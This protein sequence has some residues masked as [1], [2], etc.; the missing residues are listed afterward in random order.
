MIVGTIDAAS[1]IGL[2]ARAG[3]MTV[4]PVTTAGSLLMLGSN[5]VTLA[6]ASTGTGANQAVYIADISMESL[7]GPDFD[8]TPLFAL[9]PVRMAGPITINGAITTGSF[10]AASTGAFSAQS[11]SVTGQLYADTGQT[12][13]LTAPIVVPGDVTLTGDGGIDTVDLQAGGDV[14]LYT[15]NGTISVVDIQAG[16][17]AQ[18]EAA[19]LISGGDITAFGVDVLSYG[20]NISL[21][22]LASSVTAADLPETP[23]GVAVHANGSVST[24]AISSQN[25]VGLVA[26]TGGI[27]TNMISAANGDVGVLAATGAS[28]GG[29]TTAPTGTIYIA[30]VSQLSLLVPPGFDPT[31]LFASAPVRINGSV[32]IGGPVST[33]QFTAAGQSFT[34]QGALS[35]QTS[36]N[37]DVAGLATF[38]GIA[39]APTIRVA[40]GDIA[41][42]ANGG[43]GSSGTTSLTLSTT[44][45]NAVIGG[46]GT[47]SGYM[48]DGA[49]AQRVRAANIL[50]GSSGNVELRGL[51]LNGA[52][53][54][55]G[56]NITNPT[57]AFTVQSGGS[58][59]VTGAVRFDNMSS[60]NALR[61]SAADRVE[62][63][64]DTGSIGIYG[65]GTT[66]GGGLEI[67]GD[68]IHVASAS[69]LSQLASNPRF[70]GRDQAL[71]RA[72]GQSRPEGFIQAGRIQLAGRDTILI[73]NSNSTGAFGGFTAGQGGLQVISLAASTAPT[74][75][76]IYGRLADGS[77]GFVI[78]Q[79]VRDAISISSSSQGGFSASSSVN[80]CLLSASVCDAAA[81]VPEQ[82]D[83]V[84]SIATDVQAIANQSADPQPLLEEEEQE[85]AQKATSRSPIARPVALID[86]RPMDADP[87][88]EEP[89]T[90]GGNPSLIGNVEPS[91]T[92]SGGGQ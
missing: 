38:N 79:D 90:S 52:Q 9:L 56:A 81:P 29:I 76:V 23:F 66:L 54:G 8:P 36:I 55:S 2:L 32:T 33:G 10:G 44:A 48:L 40:S 61:L 51:T 72:G 91:S 17:I 18:L 25:S 50:F 14:T 64:T 57:G 47:V 71:A 4:G 28:L 13:T 49:E 42:S 39:T 88:V 86:T 45:A 65:S 26:D 7:L 20:G 43:L 5:G 6:G 80:G 87:T 58:I 53:A 75:L 3:T 82:D 35:A 27:S 22:D 21:G 30:D 12:L 16:G 77:G 60:A 11:I 83:T 37:V 63:V 46:T 92:N 70:S 74:D 73:Q 69:L 68:N 78:H 34:A 15:V 31:A 62:V 41:I 89:V 24:G 19:G 59:R 84:V 85:A 67:V 1:D